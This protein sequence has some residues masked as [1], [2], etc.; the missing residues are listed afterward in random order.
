[1]LRE[2]LFDLHFNLKQRIN[3][4]KSAIVPARKLT[5]AEEHAVKEAWGSDIRISYCERVLGVFIGL[6]ATIETQYDAALAKLE[7]ALEIYMGIR[8][9]LTVAIRIAVS[10]VFL[11]SLL[12][13]L[14]AYPN[15]H[16]WMPWTVVQRVEAALLKFIA[17]IGWVKLRLLSHLRGVYGIRQELKDLRLSNVAALLSS[18]G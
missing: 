13:T 11:V 1:M 16:F 4:E 6:D 17:P 7:R 18:Y 5:T 2:Q 8:S 12:K 15:R 14:F 9:D 10:N 3:K